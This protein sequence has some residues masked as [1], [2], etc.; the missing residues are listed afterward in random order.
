MILVSGATGTVGSAL[1]PALVA[2]GVP[3][4]ALVRDLEKARRALPAEVELVQGD[5]GDAASLGRALDGADAFFLNSP[6]LEGFVDIQ[7]AAISAGQRAGVP[8][9]VRLSVL[10]ASPESTMSFGRG[11]AELDAVLAGTDLDWTALA[12]NAFFQ[13]FLGS[14]P[15]IREGVLYAPVADAAVSYI[16]ARDIADVAAEVLTGQGHTHQVYPLTGPAAV[17][18]ADVAAALSA[19]LGRDVTYTDVPPETTRQTLLGFGVPPGQ[20]EDL[21]ELYRLFRSGGAAAVAPT[22]QE[23]TGRPGR[24]LADFVR[25]YKAAFGG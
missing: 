16:D 23:I 20:V 13:N 14:A 4:R 7:R 24:T 3:T 18:H 22:G 11:H 12:P 17:T 21:L 9:L 10:G 25:D 8:R 2:R 15:T 19:E 6:S 5:L 1:V